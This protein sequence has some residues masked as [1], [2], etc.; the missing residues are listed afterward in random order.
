V[1]DSEVRDLRTPFATDQNVA[2]RNVAVDDAAL[3]CGGEAARDLRRN[4]CGATR[5]ERADTAQH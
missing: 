3:M 4:S 5:H 1:S 2:R